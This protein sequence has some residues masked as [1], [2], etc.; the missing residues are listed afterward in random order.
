M[1]GAAK[2]IAVPSSIA[3]GASFWGAP[4]EM[5]ILSGDG[6]AARCTSQQLLAASLSSSR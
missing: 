6:I 4:D 2:G 3:G 5:L 1:V